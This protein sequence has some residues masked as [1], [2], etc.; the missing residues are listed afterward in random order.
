M[1][2]ASKKGDDGST[3][4]LFGKRVSK[5]H[6]RIEANGALD[7]LSSTL[8]LCRAQQPDPPVAALLHNI[9]ERLVSLMTELA[10]DDAD[11]DRPLP[12]NTG[13]LSDV[14]LKI[15]EQAIETRENNDGP[16]R[17]WQLPGANSEEAFFDLA[18]TTCRRAERRVVQLHENGSP[19]RPL[20]LQYLNRLSDLLWLLA[21]AARNSPTGE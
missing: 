16:F 11:R 9:Q 8:G 21:R 10:I 20:I 13:P 3:G 12:G 6:A 2:I 17:N 7:E 5:S 15:L 4:L 18:R 1:N 19:V 14:D